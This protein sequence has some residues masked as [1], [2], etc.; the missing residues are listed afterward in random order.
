MSYHSTTNVSPPLPSD[1]PTVRLPSDY[2]HGL[3]SA[4][5]PR[6][7]WLPS[8]VRAP[9]ALPSDTPVRAPKRGS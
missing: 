7:R 4:E 3:P 8:E 1:L 5:R 2:F 9:A 6:D